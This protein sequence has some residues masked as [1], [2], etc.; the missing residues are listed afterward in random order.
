MH[1]FTSTHFRI[2]IAVCSGHVVDIQRTISHRKMRT[3]WKLSCS[4]FDFNPLTTDSDTLKT[5]LQCACI[6]NLLKQ[7]WTINYLR[8]L[9]LQAD[10]IEPRFQGIF[11]MLNFRNET[12]REAGQTFSINILIRTISTFHKYHLHWWIIRRGVLLG[13]STPR[14]HFF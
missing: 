5:V 2:A 1:S 4:R 9:A 14:S 7:I 11:A 10:I 8:F 6:C 13:T 12:S 3:L